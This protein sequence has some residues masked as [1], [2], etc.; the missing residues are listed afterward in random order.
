METVEQAAAFGYKCGW[1]A[2]RA[3]APNEVIARIGIEDV[4]QT[5]WREGIE[6]AYERSDDRIV[7]ATPAI[8]GWVLV[9]GTSL[10]SAAAE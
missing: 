10:L 8:D 2:I 5:A 3:S 6:A 7:Y 4:R 9:V 1:L